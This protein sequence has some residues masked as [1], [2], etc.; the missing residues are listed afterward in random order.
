MANTLFNFPDIESFPD[1]IVDFELNDI[2]RITLKVLAFMNVPRSI[3]TLKIMAGKVIP[4][5]PHY[6]NVKSNTVHSIINEFKKLN[7]IVD[8]YEGCILEPAITSKILQSSKTNQ[9]IIKTAYQVINENY[10][11]G[12]E[13]TKA[14]LAILSGDS[15]IMNKELFHSHLYYYENS[16][17]RILDTL[18]SIGNL[19][20]IIPLLPTFPK[21]QKSEFLYKV[22]YYLPDRFY[23]SWADVLT[24]SKTK[25]DKVAIINY[26]SC[27]QLVLPWQL[28]ATIAE[29]F[30][31]EKSSLFFLELLKG[32]PDKAFLVGT[33][34]L[35]SYQ[36]KV[37]HTRKELPGVFGLL[38][39][40]VLISTGDGKDLANAATFARKTVSILPDFDRN[41]NPFKS[42][43]QIVILYINHKLGKKQTDRYS[44][45]NA[46]KSN[47]RTHFYTAVMKW[48]G[49]ELDKDIPAGISE[50][51]EMEFRASGL[52]NR[53][54]STGFHEKRLSELKE[55][56]ATVPLAE[57]FKA[58]EPWEKLLI[59]LEGTL[60]KPATSQKGTIEKKQRLIWQ[61]DPLNSYSLQPVE[62]SMNKSGWSKGKN[63]SLSTLFKKTP[64]FATPDDIKVINCLTK[65]YH[66]YYDIT[67]R[68]W[69]TLMEVLAEHP[70]VYTTGQPPLPLEI[71]IQQAQV[72]IDRSPEG[73]T[74]KLSPE[75][76]ESNV[77]KE[78][79]TRYIYYKWDSKAIQVYNVLKEA[80]TSI[81]KI[82][83][84]G[85]ERAR[86]VIE[87]LSQVLPVTGNFVKSSAPTKKSENI[88]VLQLTP[89]NTQLHVQ[90]LIELV[91]NE[92]PRL[93][94]G[95]GSNEILIETSGGKKLNI[96]R[97]K[98]KE[99]ELLLELANKVAWLQEMKSTSAQMF[100]DN[101][102]D[103][104]DFLSELKEKAPDISVIWPQGER[105]RV[106]KVVSYADLRIN[107]KKA[108]NWFEL[109]GDVDVDSKIKL[110]VQQL[111]EK[112][113]GGTL[114][115]IQLDDKTFLSIQKDLLKRL[116]TLDAVAHS[117]GGK[118]EVHPL[119]ASTVESA[120]LDMGQVIT[121]KAWKKH[122][123]NLSKMKE[124]TPALPGN[125]QAV[126]RPYQEE[127]I[128]WLDRMHQWGV[129]CCLADDMG[130][131]KTLQALG[132]MLKYATKGPSL[133]IAPSSVC[134][135]WKKE[136]ERF[137][138]TL[139]PKALKNQNRE[140]DL[141]ELG[142]FDVLIVSY[143]II[144]SNPDLLAQREWNTVVLDEAHAI[145][146]AK[147][148]RAKAVMKLSAE[149][150]IL[151]TGTPIQ[152]HIGDLWSLFHFMNPGMLGSF[153][154][155]A[156][157]YGQGNNGELARQSKSA[158]NRYISPF[159]LRRNKNDVLDD[160]PEKTEINLH[161][162]LSDEERAM[163]EVLRENAIAQI[164]GLE[165]DGGSKHI[166]IL[167]EITKL[168]QMSCNPRLVAPDCNIPSSKL[169]ALENLVDDL[170]DARHQALVFSQFTKHL[171][172]IREMLDRKKIRY[173]YLDGSTPAKK[174]EQEIEKF[175]NGES[176]LFLI[177]LK[178]GGVGLNLTAADYVIHMDPWWNPAVE[179]QASDRA[180]R[181]GQTRPVT[182]YRLIAENTIEEKI[183]KMH[184]DKRDLADK[185]LA[186]TDQ[187]AKISS[188]ELF[189]LIVEK[190]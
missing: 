5:L 142:N 56:F 92:E 189:N 106:A 50:K 63:R 2:E 187:S 153:E 101:D 65:D 43:A 17:K 190:D 59:V 47:Y 45:G 11:W 109:E 160:L 58:E 29:R 103:I 94:P 88:P 163:Y 51:E 174:R 166:Q 61:V 98:E 22:P 87:N 82:P 181:I 146:N 140:S 36:E 75:S 119:G 115:Y 26:L 90:L 6:Q 150:K 169:E 52:K 38:Y 10:R 71:R 155:F 179:D 154:Q 60:Q 177:S 128:L 53:N 99:K 158:L 129:G 113:E 180:H 76:P 157:K 188:D 161:I 116:N 114:Q 39:A 27:A 89:V 20:Y 42:F 137:S 122:L 46:Y 168:R 15:T 126:L 81:L 172:I 30:D 91:K 159:I 67:V 18:L 96:K 73:A 9:S 138:P 23:E 132:I 162:S 83:K 156:K 102:Y 74:I 64:D 48:I 14:R 167:A 54:E 110:S 16:H 12:E 135:N 24:D 57:I 7:L 41:E 69:G 186:G 55:K 35:L 108:K 40:L 85:L 62:Q 107:I 176:E 184:H 149:F 171:A 182:I 165:G 25:P 139:V 127:G 66:Y 164:N 118:L 70:H 151:T 33:D 78:T 173:Q 80:G 147:S 34:Y 77:Q 86:P 100:L 133:V 32:N 72:Q 131:G 134:H 178:A 123:D 125:L 4:A 143:G 120:L 1:D 145:K 124:Y 141:K 152:N 19:E 148:I 121:D 183:V 97:N 21:D 79:N 185:L 68:N 84:Q 104:L 31:I 105:L 28:V 49:H 112:S 8:H 144:Q 95:I 175:Q 3:T 37:G 117:K 111:L 170:I 136:I 93:V 13:R 44:I 130:L